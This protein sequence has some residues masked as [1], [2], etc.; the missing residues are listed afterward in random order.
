MVSKKGLLIILSSPSG[1]GKTSVYKEILRR[2]P[3]IFYSVSAT[4]RPKRVNEIDH[5]S[6]HYLSEEEFLRQR[7][8]GLFAEWAE[9]YGYYYGTYK[10]ILD[11]VVQSG[12]IALMD[13]DTQGGRSLS[14]LYQEAVTIFILPP[15]LQVLKERLMK[16]GTDDSAVCERRLR[17]ALKEIREWP[18][19]KYV[20]V[21]DV[22]E[23][24]VKSVETIIA[25]ESLRSSIYTPGHFERNYYTNDYGLT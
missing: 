10:S 16:R 13:L 25:A 6:Y 2:N 18:N 20:V 9:V 23:E 4:T 17:E 14:A 21:N 24:T 12:D 5:E 22:L 7:D 8:S 1:G 15:S 11:K 3:K 19:Y